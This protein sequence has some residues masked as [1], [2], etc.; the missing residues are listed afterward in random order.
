MSSH[1]E[2]YFSGENNRSMY[3]ARSSQAIAMFNEVK[4][5]FPWAQKDDAFAI[6]SSLQHEVL[7][8]PV[9]SLL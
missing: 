7:G 3:E 6:S 2:I 5:V 8:E 4:A 1:T 9:I